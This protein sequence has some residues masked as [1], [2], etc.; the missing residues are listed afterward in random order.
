VDYFSHTKNRTSAESHHKRTNCGRRFERT[1]NLM[2]KVTVGAFERGF[3]SRQL[4]V[5]TKTGTG[6]QYA[7][8]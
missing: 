8:A 7:I 5:I 6:K 3:S 1:E 4:P 2:Q